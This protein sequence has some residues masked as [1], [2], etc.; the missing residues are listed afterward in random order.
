MSNEN[1]QKYAA[2]KRQHINHIIAIAVMLVLFTTMMISGILAGVELFAL[3]ILGIFGG[4]GI[5]LVY[6]ISK[7]SAPKEKE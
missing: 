3:I 6:F 4:V 5:A 1:K 2:Y 7:P